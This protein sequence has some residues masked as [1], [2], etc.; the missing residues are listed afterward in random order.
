VFRVD[1]LVERSFAIANLEYA[2]SRKTSVCSCKRMGS[3]VLALRRKIMQKWEYK[4]I[5]VRKQQVLKENY[6][7]LKAYQLFDIEYLNELGEDGWELVSC[8]VDHED[9]GKPLT[10]MFKR[11]TADLWIEDFSPEKDEAGP[12]LSDS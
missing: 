6:Q 11:P 3:Q 2:P 9:I 12:V 4:V 1:L 8:D 10:M 7:T 5:L